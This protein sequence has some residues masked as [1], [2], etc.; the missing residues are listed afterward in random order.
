M[1]NSET[2]LLHKIFN[3]KTNGLETLGHLHAKH[4]DDL[5]K[6]ILQYAEKTVMEV[7]DRINKGEPVNMNGTIIT[8]NKN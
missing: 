1:E 2:F 5:A 6:V 7:I 8:L 3:Y 4:F